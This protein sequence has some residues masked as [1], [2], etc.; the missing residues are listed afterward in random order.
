MN[1]VHKILRWEHPRHQLLVLITRV[2]LGIIITLKG[3]IFISN[4]EYLDSLLQY[5]TFSAGVSFWIYYIVVAH[6]LGGVFIIVGLL[7]R[8]A[9]LVLLPVLAGAVF[10]LNPGEHGLVLNGELVLS[11]LVFCMLF[12]FLFKGP[13]EISMDNYLRNHE[14]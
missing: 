3:I 5:S 9:M 8:V 6:L 11:L 7:T 12:Y 14:L 2:V 4:I 1:P 10:F 13:G